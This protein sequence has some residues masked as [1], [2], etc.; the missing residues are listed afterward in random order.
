M[1]IW[2][3]SWYKMKYDHHNILMMEP[4]MFISR[5]CPLLVSENQV[6]ASFFKHFTVICEI[7]KWSLI[8]VMLHIMVVTYKV[9]IALQSQ[10]LSEQNS[11][12]SCLFSCSLVFC[13]FRKGFTSLM[14]KA[15][16]AY[17]C[18]SLLIVDAKISM[19]SSLSLRFVHTTQNASS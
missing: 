16:N 5:F 19:P 15:S 12:L 1:N 7:Y 18:V 9:I 10:T 14:N 4:S 6:L 11:Q 2:S 17:K 8:V 3:I 13:V